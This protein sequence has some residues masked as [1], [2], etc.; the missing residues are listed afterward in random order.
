MSRCSDSFTPDADWADVD[1]IG[2]S[3]DWGASKPDLQFFE[4]VAEAAP[5]AETATFRIDSLAELPELI[6]TFN[7]AGS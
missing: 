2:T 4:R 5:A 3:D 6:A 1:L 7:A